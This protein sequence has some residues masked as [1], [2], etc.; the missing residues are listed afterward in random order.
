MPESIF[1]GDA[2]L[3]R[4]LQE[5]VVRLPF[6]EHQEV[7][8]TRFQISRRGTV[9]LVYGDDDPMQPFFQQ[10]V[11]QVVERIKQLGWTKEKRL[12]RSMPTLRKLSIINDGQEYE[13]STGYSLEDAAK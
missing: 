13:L 3:Q 7:H 9:A 2:E 8:H 1:G 10:H 4:Q 6:S 11:L 12:T 5:N